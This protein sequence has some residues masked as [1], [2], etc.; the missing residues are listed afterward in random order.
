MA[1]YTS[2]TVQDSPALTTGH[3]SVSTHLAEQPHMATDYRANYPQY[4]QSSC[5]YDQQPYWQHT[6][7]ES[8]TYYGN[9][10]HSPVVGKTAKHSIF[11]VFLVCLKKLGCI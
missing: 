9:S 3:S 6:P 8:S 4:Y 5:L 1:D 10:I 2:A 11:Q 7:V